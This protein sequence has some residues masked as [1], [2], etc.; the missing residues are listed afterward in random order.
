MKVFNEVTMYEKFL[1]DQ[2]TEIATLSYNFNKI[3]PIIGI[4]VANKFGNTLLVLEYENKP[5]LNYGPIKSYLSE[6]DKNFLDIDLISMYFSSL[7]AF[8]GENNIQNLSNLEIHGSNIKV[9]IYFLFE[10][11]MIILFLNSKVDFN[12][13]KKTQIIRFFEDKLEKYKFEF[14][15]FNA[16][17]SRKILS[18]IRDKGTFWLK[19]LNKHYIQ[20][21]ENE[22]MQ[23]HEKIDLV[24]DKIT[25]IIQTELN[26][27]LIGLPEDII[28]NLSK[29]IRNKIQDKISEFNLDFS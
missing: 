2:L 6:D 25:P 24:M 7:K 9:Q 29:E 28:S 3:P 22:F 11:Y 19:H 21:F 1:D 16:L 17:S 4:I 18:M 26:E 23:K 14:T 15:H 10:K 8:A 12:L 27:N 13:Q 5:N 20:T